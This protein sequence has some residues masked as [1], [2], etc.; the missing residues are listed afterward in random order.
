MKRR[1]VFYA[2]LPAQ[3]ACALDS[4]VPLPRFKAKALSGKSFDNESVKGKVVLLQF[5]TTWCGYCRREQ[6]AVDK[7]TKEFAN[8]LI[9]LAVNVGE[10]KAKVTDYLTGSPRA[11]NIV[12]TQDTN[13]AALFPAQGF[14]KYVVVDR[15][16]KIK[17]NQD[18]AGGTLA[19]RDL[20]AGAGLRGKESEE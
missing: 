2:L 5:W 18:G 3:L 10:S 12:L 17:G 7:L 13:L 4:G 1:D 14:P 16:G 20:L 9:V 15:T 8:D 6:P 19:L 11:C